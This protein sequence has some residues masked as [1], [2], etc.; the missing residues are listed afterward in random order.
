MKKDKDEE[1][2]KK[3]DKKGYKD[4]HDTKRAEETAADAP[5]VP[6]SEKS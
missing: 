6:R 3:K 2:K 5:N 1:S 4:K